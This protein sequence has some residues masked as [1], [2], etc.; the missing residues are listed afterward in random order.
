MIGKR[1]F[2]LL[3]HICRMHDGHRVLKTFT[4]GTVEGDVDL[5]NLVDR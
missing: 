2:Q 3:G 5:K 4:F 1:K